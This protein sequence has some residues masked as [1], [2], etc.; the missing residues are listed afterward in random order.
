MFMQHLLQFCRAVECINP[1]LHQLKGIDINT[2]KV[3]T[4]ITES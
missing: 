2:C 1:V 3:Y 4:M